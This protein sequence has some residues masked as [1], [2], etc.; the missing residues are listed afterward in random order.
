M[1]TNGYGDWHYL[2]IKSIPALLR[3][4]ASTHNVDFY[5]LNCFHSYRTQATLEKHERICYNNDHCAIVMPD[6]KHKYISSTLGKNSLRIPLV[7]YADI[8]CLLMK[9]DSCENT[10]NNSYTEK[11]SLH[12]PCRYSIVTCY[13]YDK[14]KK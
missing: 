1:I 10:S 2:A 6:E 8:E 13:S 9:M 14:T 11:K 4:V 3:G 7:I 12:V 5:C